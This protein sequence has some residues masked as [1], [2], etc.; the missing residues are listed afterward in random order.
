[1]TLDLARIAERIALLVGSIDPA[2]E[3]ER[4][5]ALDRAWAGADSEEIAKRLQDGEPTFLV[6]RMSETLQTTH[7]LA[8]LPAA[9]TVAASDGSMIAPDRHSPAQPGSTC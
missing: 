2:Q 3:R 4:F 7:P 1:M 6:A 8:A 9:Y 5:E